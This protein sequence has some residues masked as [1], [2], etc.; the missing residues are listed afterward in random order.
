M[1]RFA[2]A[3]ALHDERLVCN[4]KAW[5]ITEHHGERERDRN[6]QTLYTLCPG[7]TERGELGNVIKQIIS[8]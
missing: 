6:R 7:G 3:L 4:Q 8:P 5:A 1:R 2:L